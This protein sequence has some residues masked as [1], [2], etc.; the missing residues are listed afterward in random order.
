MPLFT[1]DLNCHCID[2]TKQFVLNLA[3]WSNPAPGTFGN[4]AAYYNNY[5]DQRR[6]T[7]QVGFGRVFRLKERVTMQIRAEFYN[8]FNRTEMANPTSSTR[9]GRRPIIAP[10][11]RTACRF[12]R[13]AAN[14]GATCRV[15]AT[16]QP[17][18]AVVRFTHPT[19]NRQAAG[20]AAVRADWVKHT[21][22]FLYLPGLPRLRRL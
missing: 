21:K 6:P 13:K 9:T 11:A 10:P 8:V 15:R 14:A 19:L 20:P 22:G 4:A 18:D 16:H 17:Q 3:A 5:R 7:E 2:P 1:A 12:N